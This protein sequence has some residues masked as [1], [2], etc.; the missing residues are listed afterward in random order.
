MDASNIINDTADHTSIKALQVNLCSFMVVSPS[1]VLGVDASECSPN[2]AVALE[3]TTKGNL[4][5]SVAP[6]NAP[7]ALNNCM[8]VEKQLKQKARMLTRLVRSTATLARLNG[9]CIPRPLP[10]LATA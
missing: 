6:S 3:T 5:D 7:L 8:K 9:H 2:S 10:V 1:F 4:P